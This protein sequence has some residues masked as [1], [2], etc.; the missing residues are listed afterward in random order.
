MGIFASDED[1]EKAYRTNEDIVGRSF[2]R[3]LDKA[4]NALTFGLLDGSGPSGPF[5]EIGKDAA[6]ELVTKV[7]PRSL[8]DNDDEK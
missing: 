4:I 5:K 8:E 2:R 1:E 6:Q 3:G 7:I